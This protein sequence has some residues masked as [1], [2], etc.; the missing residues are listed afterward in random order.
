[1]SGWDIDVDGVAFVTG[2]VGLAMRDLGTDVEAYGTDMESAAVSAGTVAGVSGGPAPTGA[3][4]AAL[5][6]FAEGT[7]QEVAILAA[8]A[9]KSVNGAHEATGYY[10]L[11]D[12]EMAA[13]AQHR[14]LAAPEVDLPG[15][16]DGGG[17]K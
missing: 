12:E 10:I 14:A 2:L 8:R 4:G 5:A 11:G 7:A 13:Q 9:A 6:L 15:R 3:V 16:G 17:H 1:M